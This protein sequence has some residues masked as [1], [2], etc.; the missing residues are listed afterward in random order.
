MDE[1]DYGEQLG[2]LRGVRGSVAALAR[3]LDSEL[4]DIGEVRL[5]L[6]GVAERVSE[7]LRAQR[8]IDEL[9][10]EREPQLPQILD[11]VRPQLDDLTTRM[12]AITTRLRDVQR[13]QRRF[14]E[15]LE[16]E[17]PELERVFGLRYG[18]EIKESFGALDLAFLEELDEEF[19]IGLR[20][21]GDVPDRI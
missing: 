16:S 10:P 12:Q 3:V 8:R 19:E 6:L 20:D 4:Q 9:Q 15:E 18:S 21:I 7:L 5:L 2:F 13:I 17:L 1:T 14:Y 11:E